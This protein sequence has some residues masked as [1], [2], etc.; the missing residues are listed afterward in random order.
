MDE[1]VIADHC[2]STVWSAGKTVVVDHAQ[3]SAVN[4]QTGSYAVSMCLCSPAV[5]GRTCVEACTGAVSEERAW[6]L[7]FHVAPS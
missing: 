4:L 1:V 6:L 3:I 5:Q 2:L 7:E